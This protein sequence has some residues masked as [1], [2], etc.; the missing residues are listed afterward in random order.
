MSWY[1]ENLIRHSIE[2]KS[3]IYG[4]INPS[5]VIYGSIPEM[6]EGVHES[7]DGLHFSPFTIDFNN[8]EYTNLL[9]VEKKIKELIDNKQLSDK[10]IIIIN[11]IMSS[12]SLSSLQKK[13][14]ITRMTISKIFTK[15]CE[16]LAYLL[17][18]D[19]TDEGFLNDLKE[20]HHLTEEEL[21]R[22]HKYMTSN[23]KYMTLKIDR[24]SQK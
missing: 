6:V 12:E 24:R 2:I 21:E 13:T 23:K 19:F 14:G 18:D 8:N 15:I 11:G 20:S 7:S 1:V 4:D 10:E 16:R 9:L 22:A 17:G 3:S 5:K